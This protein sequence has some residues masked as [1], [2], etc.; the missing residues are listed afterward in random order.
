MW[1]SLA[2]ARLGKQGI[3]F[4]L[5]IRVDVAFLVHLYSSRDVDLPCLAIVGWSILIALT[6]DGY[7]QWASVWRVGGVTP[8]STDAYRHCHWSACTGR[9][10]G[11]RRRF[12]C[13]QAV[14]HLCAGPASV[15]G[16]MQAVGL[17]SL[18]VMLEVGVVWYSLVFGR[19]FYVIS[20]FTHVVFLVLAL[21]ELFIVVFVLVALS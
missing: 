2:Q 4:C 21:L 1:L 8:L 9:A 18:C 11:L 7:L 15:C 12:C 6:S 10:V 16:V 19:R 17:S 20:L 14:R 3:R 13:G 5:F